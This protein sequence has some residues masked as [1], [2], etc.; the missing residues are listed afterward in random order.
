[1]AR[2]LGS[3]VSSR[4]RTEACSGDLDPDSGCCGH[5]SSGDP[6]AGGQ[7]T[8]ARRAEAGRDRFLADIEQDPRTPDFLSFEPNPYNP[9]FTPSP[10]RDA[11]DCDGVLTGQ[12]IGTGDT[13]YMVY[14]GRRGREWQTGLARTGKLP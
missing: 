1:M 11:W 5:G 8:P 3:W 14:A 6:A 10:D 9:V 2:E 4:A 12:V 7:D 13:Y